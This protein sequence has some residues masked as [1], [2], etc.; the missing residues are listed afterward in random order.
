[1]SESG[2]NS[3]TDGGYVF[4]FVEWRNMKRAA[5]EVGQDPALLRFDFADDQDLLIVMQPAGRSGEYYEL[6]YLTPDQLRDALRLAGLLP[7]LVEG[8]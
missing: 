7:D 1:M 6:G 8:V 5:R 3:T 2:M 4:D